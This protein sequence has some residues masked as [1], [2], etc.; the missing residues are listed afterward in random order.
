MY[1]SAENFEALIFCTFIEKVYLM[2]CEKSE[3]LEKFEY[4]EIEMR[5]LVLCFSSTGG[6][7]CD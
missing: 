4:D 2:R 6:S 3:T 5:P 1:V 7:I